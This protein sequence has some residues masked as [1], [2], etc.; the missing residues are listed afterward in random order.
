MAIASV[1]VQTISTLSGLKVV[2]G[3]FVADDAD[4][5][6]AE[7][8]GL[9]IFE[10]LQLT[11]ATASRIASFALDTSKANATLGLVTD[12]GGAAAGVVLNVLAI[13]T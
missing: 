3:T 10:V 9:K 5:L 12:A 11:P 2:T 7:D 13:G 6:D 8:I 1:A 4:V